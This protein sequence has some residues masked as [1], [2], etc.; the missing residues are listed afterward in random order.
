MESFGEYLKEERESRSISL[1][2]VSAATRIRKVFLEA[3][4]NGDMHK[5]PAEIFVKGFLRAYSKYLGMDNT[6]VILR[7][8]TYLDSLKK[9]EEEAPPRQ[10]SLSPKAMLV[11]ASAALVLVF[12]IGLVI[13]SGLSKKER[14][15]TVSP[16]SPKAGESVDA[17]PP[18]EEANRGLLKVLE[19]PSTTI[20]SVDDG[21][22]IPKEGKKTLLATASE[23]T[24]LRIQID[25]N[26]PFEVTLRSGESFTWSGLSRFKL[27]IGNAGGLNLFYNGK[28]IGSLG[29]SGQ[30]VS[31]TLPN[32][33]VR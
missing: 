1:E 31:L 28:G 21:G 25:D 27:L 19:G 29:D 17:P 32:E 4:E 10:I 33:R 24:W 15:E 26:L 20:R 30:V 12:L 23:M 6:E 7:Y 16:V 13:Y 18:P 11:I 22:S 8:Q 2:E 9:V 14:V 5:L 3:I